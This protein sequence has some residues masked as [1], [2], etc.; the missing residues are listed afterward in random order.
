MSVFKNFTI[1][2]AVVFQLFSPAAA[3]AQTAETALKERISI[4]ENLWDLSGD[5]KIINREGRQ[6]LEMKSGRAFV[7]DRI[8]SSGVYEFEML[9]SGERSF[10]GVRF[11]GQE[12]RN[13]ELFYIRPHQSGNPDASQYTP[14][15]NGSSAWQLYHGDGFAAPIEI[16]MQ[17]WFKIRLDIYEDSALISLNG[18]PQLHIVD[19][20]LNKSEG[21]FGFGSSFDGALY[22]DLEITPIANYVDPKEAEPITPLEPGTVENWMVSGAMDEQAARNLALASKW[23]DVKWSSLQVDKSGVANL[24][25]IA[26]RSKTEF[27]SIAKITVESDKAVSVPMDLAFSDIVDVF[28][29]GNPIY[30]GDDS[31]LSRDYRFLGSIGFYDQLNIALKPGPNEVVFVVSESFGGWGVGARF[32]DESNTIKIVQ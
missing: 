25:K 24:A 10:P 12:G 31:Y 18:E 6:V 21:Y 3:Y 29:N 27:T 14:V 7:K 30:H 23:D 2:T 4:T 9:V 15:F 19:L 28:V 22:A 16:P 26:A 5:A 11:L 8:F 32:K 1:A 17:E 13:N 20:L